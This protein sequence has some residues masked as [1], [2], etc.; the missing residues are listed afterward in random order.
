M[1][2]EI[3]GGVFLLRFDRGVSEYDGTAGFWSEHKFLKG[4]LLNTM[5]GREC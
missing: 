4:E 5:E 3:P 1:G 2:G